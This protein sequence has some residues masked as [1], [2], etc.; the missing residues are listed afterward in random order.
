MRGMFYD[1]AVALLSC[2]VD[3]R[4]VRR[5]TMEM[6]IAARILFWL[7]PPAFRAVRAFAMLSGSGNSTTAPRVCCSLFGGV[8]HEKDAAFSS[9][10]E[11]ADVDGT[12][13]SMLLSEEDGDDKPRTMNLTN[14]T[15]RQRRQYF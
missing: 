10:A 1:V 4:N 13:S 7:A 12:L 5:T 15:V 2:R 8:T 14:E 9:I 3:L 11:D 6:P